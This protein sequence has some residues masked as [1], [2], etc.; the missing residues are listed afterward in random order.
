MSGTLTF[1]VM[2]MLSPKAR[3]KIAAASALVTLM[4]VSR[5]GFLDDM[6]V[7]V[8]VNQ[9]SRG[10]RLNLHLDGCFGHIQEIKRRNRTYRPFRM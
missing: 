2:S 1:T 3:L 5:L 6:C 10:P 4:F 7:S 9:K 8:L